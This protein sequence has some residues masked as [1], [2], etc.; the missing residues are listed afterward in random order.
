M[1][2]ETRAFPGDA[3][4]FEISAPKG[5]Q[6]IDMRM[7]RLGQCLVALK[8]DDE[9]DGEEDIGVMVLMED[10]GNIGE[11]MAEEWDHVGNWTFPNGRIAHGFRR[12][13]KAP[14]RRRSNSDT[15]DRTEPE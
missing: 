3:Q 13:P 7:N 1:R 4:T 6:V 2:I 14:K 11:G 15:V 5:A 10:Q 9:A 12:R 8:C